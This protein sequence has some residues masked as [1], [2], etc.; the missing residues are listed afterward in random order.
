M[1]LFDDEM[2]QDEFDAENDAASGGVPPAVPA[3][4]ANPDLVGFEAVEKQFITWWQDGVLPHTLILAG[5]HGI[6]KA[7]LAYRLARFLLANPAP[8]GADMFGDAV[9]PEN[10]G[11]AA[12]HPVFLKVASGGHPDLMTL[13]RAVNDKT[14]ATQAEIV[15]EGAREV[16]SFLRRTASDGGWRVVIIDE[17]E[18]LNRNAQNALLKILEEPP[19]KALLILVTQSAGALIPTIRSRARVMALDAPPF[20]VFAT[21]MRRYR[22]DLP[23]GDLALLGRVTGNAPG[24]ALSLLDQGGME[25]IREALD[26][27]RALPRMD[28]ATLWTMAEKMAV[29][30]TPDPLAGMLDMT[31]WMLRD[32]ARSA[33]A[34]DRLDRVKACL[35]TLDALEDHRAMCDR[36]NLDR[37]YMAMGALRILQTGLRAG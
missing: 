10:L 17:A 5:A 8:A 36:G 15:V 37:R 13:A 2:D 7:T 6:G 19:S 20:D 33:G 14:G 21:L 28:D 26:L 9:V 22:P 35:A 24:R 25:A 16:P 11:V 31:A 29:K 34:A 4:R 32:E 1:N 30:S 18:T 3:P 12:G 27:P 23:E